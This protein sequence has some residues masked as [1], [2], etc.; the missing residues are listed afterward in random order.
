MVIT[1]SSCFT[2]QPKTSSPQQNQ[3]AFDQVGPLALMQQLWMGS[4]QKAEPDRLPAVHEGSVPRQACA[5]QWPTSVE[6]LVMLIS[7]TDNQRVTHQV[8]LL[9]HGTALLAFQKSHHPYGLLTGHQG[10]THQVG[11]LA[12]EA[13]RCLNATAEVHQFQRARE[14]G[15]A[16]ELALH[17]RLQ[18]GAVRRVRQ[19]IHR[20]RCQV[21][22]R[23]VLTLRAWALRSAFSPTIFRLTVLAALQQFLNISV[24]RYRIAVHL[25]SYCRPHKVGHETTCA[26]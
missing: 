23:Q 26:Q 3:G 5:L 8:G 6:S 19:R 15:T 11:L 14:G 17:Q 21:A 2:G 13:A 10:V 16:V 25:Q 4:H 9:A 22:A 1:A 20:R 18:L 12:R 24:Q 7:L